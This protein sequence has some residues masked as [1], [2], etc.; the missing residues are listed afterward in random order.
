VLAY[1]LAVQRILCK[2][3][4]EVILFFLAADREWPIAVTDEAIGEA[5]AHIVPGA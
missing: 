1:A 2:P 3:V 5:V 4:R